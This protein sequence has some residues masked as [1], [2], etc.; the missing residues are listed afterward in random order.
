M[1]SLSASRAFFAAM[2]ASADERDLLA[3]PRRFL[4]VL[5]QVLGQE[6][7]HDAGD[8]AL[9]LGVVQL[10]LRLRL[11]LRLRVADADDGGQA[12]A[13]VLA[14]QLRGPSLKRFSFLP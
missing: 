13:E 14:L 7:V 9:D 11:E 4:R 10:D 8:D 1:R 5:L 12:L 6:L 2:R 3:D